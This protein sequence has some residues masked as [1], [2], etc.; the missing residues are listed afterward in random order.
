MSQLVLEAFGVTKDYNYESVVRGARGTNVKS[1]GG[2]FWDEREE[3]RDYD[4]FGEGGW[5]GEWEEDEFCW[6][7]WYFY[8]ELVR[9]NSL[10]FFYGACP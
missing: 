2:Y 10:V 5:G 9:I 6:I 4:L 8:G 3:V 7:A 1:R